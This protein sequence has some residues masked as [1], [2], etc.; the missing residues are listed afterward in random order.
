M[1]HDGREAIQR[2]AGLGLV[3]HAGAQVQGAMGRIVGAIG[4]RVSSDVAQPTYVAGVDGSGEL[5]VQLGRACNGFGNK[6]ELLLG[7]AVSAE[8]VE[9]RF[10][11]VHGDF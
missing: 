9:E 8:L 7:S 4:R 3:Q 6:L 11:P 1:A 10:A 5:M 2:S